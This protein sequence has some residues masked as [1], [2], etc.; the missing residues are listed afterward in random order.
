MIRAVPGGLRRRGGRPDSLYG[1]AYASADADRSDDEERDGRR[2]GAD[3]SRPAGAG[4][5]AP[6]DALHAH[7]RVRRGARGPDRRPRRG[8]P[9]LRPARPALPRRA[10]RPV[11]REHRPR[12]GHGGPGRR[13]AGA[14]AGL[15]LELVLRAPQGDRAR[16]ADRRPRARR[17]EPRVLHLG[18]VRGGRVGPE[19]VPPVPQAHGQPRP[20][21]GRLPQAGLPRDDD[22]RAGRDGHPGRA[23]AVRA[24]PPRLRARAEHERLPPRGRRPGRGDP[25]ADRVRGAGDRLLRDPRARAELG[26]LPGAARRATS[27]ACA[28]SATS[29]ACCSSPTR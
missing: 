1:S 12:A 14:R 13:R 15:L 20:L 25:R 28:R 10:L 7:G 4:P 26:R 27:S 21:Q 6:V 16:R 29:T 17:P 23:R 24:A 18:R 3:D 8:L 5:P 22:G 11:L 19:A 2:R 9:R